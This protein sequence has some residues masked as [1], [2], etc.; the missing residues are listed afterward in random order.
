MTVGGVTDV[1]RVDW[2]G[3]ETDDG[4]RDGRDDEENNGKVEV[5]KLNDGRSSVSFTTTR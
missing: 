2:R 4:S 3:E 1:F 5:M